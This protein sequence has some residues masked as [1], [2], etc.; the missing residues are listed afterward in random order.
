M[1]ERCRLPT[2]G[3][4]RD[5][6]SPLKLRDLELPN[7]I[8]LPP[9]CQYQATGEDGVPTSWH[10]IHYGSRAVGGFGLIIAESTGVVPEGRISNY[11][12]GLW[13]DKQTDAWRDV[14]E[15]VHDQD[16][17][18]AIQ[19]NHAG[20]KA[21]GWP[22]LPE[23]ALAQQ[24]SQPSTTPASL[25]L[26][27]G[28]WSTVAPSAVANEGYAE[29]RALSAAEVRENPNQF[30]AAAKRAVAAGFDA[31]EIHA[32]HG[33][34]LHQFLS[35][36]ANKRTD[37]WG[38]SFENRIRLVCATVDA[39]RSAIPDSMPLLIRISAT[40][41]LGGGWT[42]EESGGLLSLLKD[43]GVD[44]ADV[45]TG[46][47]ARAKIPVGPNYQISAASEVRRMSGLPTA[48]VGLITEPAQADRLVT[49]G[50][51]DAV[52]IGRAALRDPYW[53]LRAA[54]ELGKSDEIEFPVPYHRGTFT[55]RSE[56]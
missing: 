12:T 13:S 9:M 16:G 45:S 2:L 1:R 24:R 5:M 53:P 3:G 27:A 20:R 42:V 56:H 48:G 39:V 23:R 17:R 55:D 44:A 28:G 38:G 10:V 46:G 33:Y 26:D 41:W 25:P 30:A 49:A 37:D 19:L 32:A 21:S 47:V 7:R 15:A 34:L 36:I 4:M 40:D 31:I 54:Y 6:F 22:D 52:M 50:E 11:C 14:V 29:P 35:P 51:V 43:Y 18:L 8:W